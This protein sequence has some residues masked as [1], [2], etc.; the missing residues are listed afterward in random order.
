MFNRTRRRLVLV[1]VLVLFVLLN[2]MGSMVY[3]YTN[4]RLKNQVDDTLQEQMKDFKNK[5]LEDLQKLV[6]PDKEGDHRLFYLLWKKGDTLD[7]M[8]PE[9]AVA[10]KDVALFA[11]ANLQPGFQSVTINGTH[12]RYVT[13]PVSKLKLNGKA[14]QGMRIQILYNE[15]RE[16]DMLQDLLYV[17]GISDF[18]SLILAIFA[19]FYLAKGSLIPIRK[20]WQ[21]QQQFVADASHELRTPLSV[22]KLNLEYLFRH[23]DHTIEEDSEIILQAINEINYLT[24]MTSELLTLARSDA[25]ELMIQQDKVRLDQLI[26]QVV[27]EIRPFAEARRVD[28][29]LEE[30]EPLEMNGDRERLKQLFII[31]FDNGIKY[32]KEQG[33]VSI[34]GEKNGSKLR[35]TIK[36]EGIGI[37][38]QDLPYI[39]DRYFRG[40]RSRTRQ[41]EGTGL[42]L[43]IAK[44][45]VEAHEGRIRIESEEG[46]GTQVTLTFPTN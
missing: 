27:R 32:S 29:Q 12:F 15:Q 38:R 6:H 24:K 2:F 30:L 17:I 9:N 33:G 40:D 13:F 3:L 44:W 18:I 8:F 43:S 28:L 36:D 7:H 23:P 10:K 37:P 39:F 20:A 21:K 26:N 46:K 5:H 34:S 1:N 25:D 45:I 11:K 16:E 41:Y 14:L 19:G 31:L 4:Y 42:G 22:T 35:V